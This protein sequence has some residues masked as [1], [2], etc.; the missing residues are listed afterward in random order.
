AAL[1]QDVARTSEQ[2]AALLE[3][4][5]ADIA[6]D[7]RLRDVAPSRLERL[8]QL[9]LCADALPRDHA[10]DQALALR[11]PER[12]SRNLHTCSINIHVC[13]PCAPATN[14]SCSASWPGPDSRLR[15]S[16]SRGG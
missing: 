2:V 4:E 16:S 8:Q 10:A 11:L 14:T 9:E 7:R 6:R 5:L 1:R 12:A 3:A 13:V 15:R